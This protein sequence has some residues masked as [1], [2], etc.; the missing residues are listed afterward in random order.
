LPRGLHNQG[1][2]GLHEFYEEKCKEKPFCCD[3]FTTNK[4][5]LQGKAVFVVVLNMFTEYKKIAFRN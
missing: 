2:S 5:K 4:I 1:A 3:V